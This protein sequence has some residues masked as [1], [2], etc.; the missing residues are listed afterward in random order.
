ME[1]PPLS[2]PTGHHHHRQPHPQTRTAPPASRR[3]RSFHAILASF[4]PWLLATVP[5]PGQ[6]ELIYDNTTNYRGQYLAL[7]EEF[8]DEVDFAGTARTISAITFSVLGETNLPPDVTARFRLYRNNGPLLPVEGVS[9]PT[10]GELLYE[11]S[12]IPILPGQQT[13]RITDIAVPV[14]NFVTWTIL[15]QNVGVLPGT[16]AGLE[17]FHPPTVGSSFRDYWVRTVDGFELRLLDAGASASFAARFEAIP[18]PP[19]VVTVTNSPEGNL[20]RVTGP[21]GGEHILETSGDNRSWRTLGVIRLLTTSEGT[22]FHPADASGG[23]RYYRVRPAP[24]P[25]ST[26]VIDSI[27]RS[28]N[29]I[30]TLT[31]SGP[32]NTVQLL[33]TSPDQ[34]HWKPVDVI[35]LIFG[36]AT[37]QDTIR[38]GV[39]RFYRT[40][41]PLGRG[42]VYLIRSIRR[43]PDGSVVLACSGLPDLNP[44]TVEASTDLQTWTPIG[45]IRFI[46]PQAEFRDTTAAENP[47][48]IYRIRR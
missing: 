21:I 7:T 19:I 3:P 2:S 17:V 16:R 9:I 5:L 40:S 12:S 1:T 47:G 35:Y 33:E 20:V 23:E 18:D 39:P 45:T 15:F 11:S 8:G 10:P 22:F 25:G 38:P 27:S 48:R 26:V 14:P 29:G 4:I 32:R 43:D 30:A 36:T 28:T 42:P 44:A 41:H 6:A 34:I 46:V 24:F 37:Y 31:F 13:L